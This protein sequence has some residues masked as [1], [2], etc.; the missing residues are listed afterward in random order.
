M[1]V[2]L[3]S[4]SGVVGKEERGK[5]GIFF[6][7]LLDESFFGMLDQ[8]PAKQNNLTSMWCLTNTPLM[9]KLV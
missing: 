9:P 5:I 1:L 8:W 7:M 4:F 3:R 6:G 2:W